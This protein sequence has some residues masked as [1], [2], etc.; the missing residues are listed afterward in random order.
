VKIALVTDTYFPRVN[1][2]SASTRLFADEF[3]RLGCQVFVYA[4]AYPSQDDE[5]G[6]VRFPSRY[7]WFDPEDRL[8]R[9]N[10]P[11]GVRHF[12]EQG[13]D[14]VHTQTPFSLGRAALGW[15]QRS[16]AALVHTY[17]TLFVAY[18]EHY[19][20][21]VPRALSIPL[22]RWA[23][24]RYCNACRR[25]VVPSSAMRDELRSYG[26][27]SP[28]EVIPTGIALERFEGRDRW[29][30]RREAGVPDSARLLLFMG[31]VAEEKNIDF[32]IDV[33]EA[34]RPRHPGLRFWIAGEGPAKPRLQRIV[35]GRGLSATV[36]FLGYLARDDWRDCY[37]AADLFVFA[38]VT[39]T[40]G[41]VVTEAMAAET[42]VVAVGAMGIRDVMGEG[43]GGIVTRLD[44][45][46]FGAAV[47]RLLRDLDLYAAKQREALHEA[48]RWSAGA[49]AER[50]L[51]LY[52]DALRGSVP[53]P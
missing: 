43:R 10:H 21:L 20:P 11:E 36:S 38:S 27:S 12:L 22:V 17:H 40:Q 52:S 42:P 8:A 23:S 41:L 5:P 49:M 18:V 6:V 34:L 26:V 53:H 9:S 24:R 19:L 2:V 3:R 37:A 15:A 35:A 45:E 48:Q 47:E 32:L 7:L 51:A 16:G 29:R 39:E 31:R 33:V 14:V 4:P 28:V 44:R 25:V 13:F 30:L 46:E 1:G 50:M